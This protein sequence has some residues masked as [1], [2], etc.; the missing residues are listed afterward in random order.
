MKTIRSLPHL[1]ALALLGASTALAQMPRTPSPEGAAVYFVS[2]VDGEVVS[3]PVTVL[4]GLKGMGIAPAGIDYPDTGHH[5]LLIDVDDLPPMDQPIPADDHHVHFGKGQTETV[6][7]LEP[8]IHTLQLVFADKNHIP[9]DPPVV[10]E[11]IT[12]RVE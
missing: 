1:I 5:H 2:P 12:I 3:S 7:E 9:H 11:K 6:L 10:S 8:G 4:F